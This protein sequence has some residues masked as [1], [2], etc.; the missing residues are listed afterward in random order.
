MTAVVR[1]EAVVKPTLAVRNGRMQ[2]KVESRDDS[3]NVKHHRKDIFA[4]NALLTGDLNG[5]MKRMG[6]V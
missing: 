2:L 6:S 5:F 4:L 1:K 3:Y